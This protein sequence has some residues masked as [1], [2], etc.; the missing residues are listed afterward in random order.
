MQINPVK[1][2]INYNYNYNYNLKSN[3]IK[4][5]LLAKP[6]YDSVS[7]NGKNRDKISK[8]AV[9][10]ALLA[11]LSG[12][13][14]NTPAP[15]QTGD[16]DTSNVTIIEDDD[17]IGVEIED[18]IED[19][20]GDKA[21]NKDKE[22]QEIN[23]LL[24]NLNALRSKRPDDVNSA[25]YQ[26][27]RKSYIEAL[28]DFTLEALDIS[29]SHAKP[30]ETPDELEKVNLYKW[31]EKIDLEEAYAV[32]EAVRSERPD[33]VNSAEYREWQDSYKSA[34]DDYAATA[35]DISNF[36]SQLIYE[37]K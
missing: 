21:E 33:D 20:A 24:K 30:D 15:S 22:T 27:W 9:S 26:E 28:E 14:S 5:G 12:C 35:F 11:T 2:S 4:S 1:N 23:A 34:L 17:E 18:E 7:F 16:I 31:Q 6:A 8:T 37:G 36:Y 32:V 29:D 10:L 13:G 3:N 19:E 25:E